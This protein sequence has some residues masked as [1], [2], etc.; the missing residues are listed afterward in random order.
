M[1]PVSPLR[2]PGGKARFRTFIA[3]AILASGEETEIFIEPFCGGAGAAIGLLE[4]SYISQIALND[5]DPLIA[6]FWKIVFGK[7][8]STSHD[9]KWLIYKVE[10]ADLSIKEWRKQKELK[11]S[12]VREAAWKCLYLNR[13][14]FNGILHKA[15]PIGGWEQKNRHL[16]VRFN[17]EKLVARLLELYNVKEQVVRVDCLNWKRFCSYFK[18]IKRT[19][20]YLDPPYYHKAEQ[21]Y[22]YIF[23]E[24]T[25]QSMRDYLVNIK[26]P[27]MLSYDDALEVRS[28]YS[29]IKGIEG[30]VID[31]TYSA[32]PVG[33]AS[34]I[35]RELF[36]SNRDLPIQNTGIPHSGLTV[37]GCFKEVSTDASGP[38]R[39]RFDQLAAVGT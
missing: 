8:R 5:C 30:R 28:L 26:S 34:F 1:T 15:G 17:K 6:S 4:S 14:S 11:P 16:G 18:K 38:I 31:Q 20:L 12:N 27:W 10:T 23:N 39:M 3:E 35:G 33:G 2:Y 25:H 22:G 37:V 29:N 32:H 9:I 21:L 7:S 19:Y 13:T 36:F 24:N